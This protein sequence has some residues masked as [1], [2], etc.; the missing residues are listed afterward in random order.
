MKT[1][2]II[3]SSYLLLTIY[4]SIETPK[5]EK[6]PIKENKNKIEFEY[7]GTLYSYKNNQAF[8]KTLQHLEETKFFIKS[9]DEKERIAEFIQLYY[10]DSKIYK[11]EL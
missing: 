9:V 5:Q 3:A 2:I 8:Y 4:S 1:L 7:Q 11:I 6:Q 10:P